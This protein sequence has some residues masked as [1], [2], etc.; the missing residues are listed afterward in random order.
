VS[1]AIARLDP[2]WELWAI[3]NLMAGAGT[4]E[5]IGAL[6]D[7]GI[8][9]SLAREAVEA[10]LGRDLVRQTRRRLVRGRRSEQSLRLSHRLRGPLVIDEVDDEERD[11]FFAQRWQAA[12]PVCFRR[13]FRSLRAVTD[14]SLE[15]VAEELG[16]TEVDVN[17][18][19]DAA[20]G[21]SS[22]EAR[23]ERMP[24]STFIGDC[25]EGR[26][27]DCYIV[28]KNGLLQRPELAPL[29]RDIGPLPA[30]L[31]GSALPKGASL[32][33]GPAGT[34]THPHF[35]PHHAFLVMLEGQKRIRIAAPDQPVLFDGMDGY[36]ARR[37]LA[38]PAWDDVKGFDREGVAE[39]VIGPG[40][41]LFIPVGYWHEVE[42]LDA[43]MMLSLLC[44][45]WDNDFHWLRP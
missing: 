20:D 6:V 37:S 23:A 21:P 5:V 32:W 24:L 17:T 8:D 45:P 9:A 14:W 7:E 25:L 11:T 42:A 41:G 30:V 13:A 19:R 31:D 43:S 15:R 1:E 10:L 44:F 3:E 33:I 39:V 40:E 38:D 2:D 34:F 27:N 18:D 22:I 29:V 28:S 35:D 12:R 16:A 4:R 26:G 36:F